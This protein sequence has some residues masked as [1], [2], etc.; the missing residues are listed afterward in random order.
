M[1][2]TISWC[3]FFQF[4]NWK[5]IPVLFLAKT[6]KLSGER[7]LL[8]HN[9]GSGHP[10]CALIMYILLKI[11]WRCIPA[12][13]AHKGDYNS[14]REAYF[15]FILFITYLFI[16]YCHVICFMYSDLSSFQ[17]PCYLAWCTVNVCIKYEI[18][19]VMWWCF[20]CQLGEGKKNN[21]LL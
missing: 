4:H 8:W 17:W 16:F 3:L 13:C 2:L 20:I 18:Y 12:P 14:S 15:S 11:N 7:D 21:Q 10:A 9:A 5:Q 1:P 6:Q 19:Y